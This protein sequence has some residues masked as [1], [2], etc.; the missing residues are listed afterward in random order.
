MK[1][2]L[3]RFNEEVQGSKYVVIPVEHLNEVEVAMGADAWFCPDNISYR[4]I[5][6]GDFRKIK[7]LLKEANKWGVTT[8]D[9]FVEE[10]YTN[11]MNYDMWIDSEELEDTLKDLYSVSEYKEHH[12]GDDGMMIALKGYCAETQ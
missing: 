10:F 7:G 11:G 3:V 9:E 2:I 6:K 12:L 4:F 5:R 1:A 8:I